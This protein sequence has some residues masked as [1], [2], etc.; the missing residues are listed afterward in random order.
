M[1]H[2]KIILDERDDML[3]IALKSGMLCQCLDQTSLT[4]S[5]TSCVYNALNNRKDDVLQKV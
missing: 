5:G 2:T 3:K 4:V 1:S